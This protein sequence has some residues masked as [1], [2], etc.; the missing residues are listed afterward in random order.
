MSPVPD[1]QQP[2][3]KQL[4]ASAFN[5]AR[6]RAIAAHEP[7]AEIRGPDHLAEVF[8]GDDARQSLPD[9]ATHARI[10]ERLAAVSPGGYEYFIARTAYIDGIVAQALRDSVPQIV[11]LG[12]GYDTR[13]F[14]FRDLIQATR[15]FELDAPATQQHKRSLL[16]QAGVAV[17][18]G[19]VFAATDF[20]QDDLASVLAG[21]GYRMDLQTLFVWEGV[22]YYLPPQTIDA[23]FAFMRQHAP[24]GSTLVF[25][26][27]ITEAEMAGRYG[28]QQARDAMRAMYT[29]EPLQFDLAEADVPAFLA[30]RGFVLRE[31]VGP[32]AMQ[33]R[34]LTLSDGALAGQV[35]D[36]FRLVLAEVE[37]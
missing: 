27:M 21:A 34:Y 9:P 14:R 32:D 12:A 15:I 22:T 29:S 19:L 28:A 1:T 10:L 30:K 8:L 36:L 13:A 26:F 25:D 11:L 4:S 23:M 5:V 33:T 31:Y 24:A 2:L 16:E 18:P 7:R 20:T 6:C 37:A 35:L 17:P 3:E